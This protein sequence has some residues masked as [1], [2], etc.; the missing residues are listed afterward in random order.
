MKC[1]ACAKQGKDLDAIATCITCGMGICMDHAIYGE[2]DV[3]IEDYRATLAGYKKLPKK[4]LKFRCS[5][6][7]EVFSGREPHT[8]LI[9]E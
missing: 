5:I 7:H 3:F 9:H 1:Y 6:C 2:Y 8:R 4:L